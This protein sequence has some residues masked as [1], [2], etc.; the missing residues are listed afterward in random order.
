MALTQLNA[1]LQGYI[2]ASFDEQPLINGGLPIINFNP[3][4]TAP[5]G[6]SATYRVL[7]PDTSTWD[8]PQPAVDAGLSAFSS[9]QG[10]APVLRRN[11]NNKLADFEADRD[12]AT[13]VL[14]QAAQIIT[15]NFIYNTTN[16]LLGSIVPAAVSGSLSSIALNDESAKRFSWTGVMTA[17]YKN[18]AA[19]AFRYVFVHPEVLATSNLYATLDTP[20]STITTAIRELGAGIKFIGQKNGLAIFS[21]NLVKK[22]GSVYETVCLTD[23]AFSVQFQRNFSTNIYFDPRFEGGSTVV[24]YKV[25]M[26]PIINGLNYAGAAGTDLGG[27]SDA[28]LGTQASWTRI[29]SIRDNQYGVAVLRSLV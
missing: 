28:L 12:G 10:I 9:A 11:K 22:V 8:T 19:P 1:V 20:S 24:G 14:G 6:N 3:E 15:D 13:E 21:S 18:G 4:W 23:N 26:A 5:Q 17:V 25:S 16:L 2:D 29:S 27:V 7:L